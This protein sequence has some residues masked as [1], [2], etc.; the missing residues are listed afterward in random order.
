MASASGQQG[1]LW[2]DSEEDDDDEDYVLQSDSEEDDS[3]SEDDVDSEPKLRRTVQKRTSA[4]D[5]EE[6]LSKSCCVKRKCHEHF[7]FAEIEQMRYSFHHTLRDGSS[8]VCANSATE[9]RRGL[10]SQWAPSVLDLHT[11]SIWLM[12]KATFFVRLSL[13]WIGRRRRRLCTS[14]QGG[15]SFVG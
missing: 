13:G 4:S 3:E 8:P 11:S 2:H 15:C 14:C 6:A 5:I 10:S 1:F 12:D 7:S 9:D